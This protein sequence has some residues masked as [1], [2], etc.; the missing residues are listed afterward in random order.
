MFLSF[1]VCNAVLVCGA[2]WFPHSSKASRREFQKKFVSEKPM[3]GDGGEKTF[4]MNFNSLFV[5]FYCI[6]LMISSWWFAFHAF[7]RFSRRNAAPCITKMAKYV[8]LNLRAFRNSF[9]RKKSTFCVFASSIVRRGGEK[10]MNSE[11]A[12]IAAVWA[13]AAIVNHV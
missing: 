13:G 6:F 9:G 12:H 8:N 3:N 1:Q 4:P 7:S 11:D 5:Y 2:L 10:V